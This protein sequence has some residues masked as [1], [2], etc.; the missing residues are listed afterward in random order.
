MV[1][2]KRLGHACEGI[3]CAY[4]TCTPLLTIFL[5]F[6]VSTVAWRPKHHNNPLPVGRK[7]VQGRGGFHAVSI[8]SGKF[9]PSNRPPNRARCVLLTAAIFCT[10]RKV[11]MKWQTLTTF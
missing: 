11:L 6:A 8:S 4:E 2:E 3:A 1:A 9:C 10:T 7:H 5:W